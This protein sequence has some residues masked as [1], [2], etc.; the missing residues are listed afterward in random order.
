[1]ED[2]N[3]MCEQCLPDTKFKFVHKV[4]DHHLRNIEFV[5]RQLKVF[6]ERILSHSQSDHEEFAEEKLAHDCWH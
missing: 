2:S 6:T 5:S 4:N 3:Q 1:M